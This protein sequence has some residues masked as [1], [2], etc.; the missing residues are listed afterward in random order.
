MVLHSHS[1]WSLQLLLQTSTRPARH[2]KFSVSLICLYLAVFLVLLSTSLHF[3]LKETKNQKSLLHAQELHRCMRVVEGS[4][5][6]R[7]KPQRSLLV[8]TKRQQRLFKYVWKVLELVF[9]HQTLYTCALEVVAFPCMLATM[10][11]S[12]VITILKQLKLQMD[13]YS[14]NI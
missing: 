6:A 12:V 4:G 14:K 11:V 1:K 5:R 3:V 8:I 10:L 13:W 7:E 2:S 9:S